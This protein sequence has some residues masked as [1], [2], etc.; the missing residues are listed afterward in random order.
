MHVIKIPRLTS[1]IV[2]GS[3]YIVIFYFSES[4]QL[5]DAF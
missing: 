1:K 5:V 3:A 2:I 4:V